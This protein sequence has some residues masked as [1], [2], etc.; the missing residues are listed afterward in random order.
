VVSFNGEK[1]GTS[2]PHQTEDWVVIDGSLTNHGALSPEIFRNACKITLTRSPTEVYGRHLIFRNGSAFV[3]E[4]AECGSLSAV[5]LP[6]SDLKLFE[7]HNLK[8][9]LR[10]VRR[11]II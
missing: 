3:A 10:L 2:L 1:P 4:G 8:G 7:K 11:Q 9:E 5:E 6:A